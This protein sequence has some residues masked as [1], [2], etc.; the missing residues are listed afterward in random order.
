MLID[1]FADARVH[2]EPPYE[3]CQLRNLSR[4]AQRQSQSESIDNSSGIVIG[5]LA[6]S[7][8]SLPRI[9]NMSERSAASGKLSDQKRV[10]WVFSFSFPFPS[11]CP[12][13]A[14][15]YAFALCDCCSLSAKDP[16]LVDSGNKGMYKP[17]EKDADD[18]PET[19]GGCSN[20][21]KSCVVM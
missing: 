1:C 15:F 13:R 5:S 3:H 16:L 12:G 17:F 10:I 14:A 19:T 21:I 2:V 20:M 4:R 9:L 18:N 8:K 6:R 7:I 11:L